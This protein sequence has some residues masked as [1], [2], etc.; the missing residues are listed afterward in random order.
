MVRTCG[1]FYIL[2]C[3]CASRHSSLPFSET[4]GSK[5]GPALRCFCAFCLANA[6]RHS[7]VPFFQIGTSKMA[8][9]PR[10]FVHFDLDVLRA[11][12]VWHFSSLCQTSTSAPATFAGLLFENQDPRMNHSKNIGIREFPTILRV[13]ILN[14]LTL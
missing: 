6:L 7:G 9:K 8:P 1:A 14:L 12:V 4:G 5:I 2:T 13:C 3:K 11:T 10:C